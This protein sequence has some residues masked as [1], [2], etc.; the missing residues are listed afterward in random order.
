MFYNDI[1]KLSNQQFK[2]LTGVKREVFELMLESLNQSKAN[3]RK[4]PRRGTPPKL[5]NADKLLLMLMYYREYRTQ[6]HIGITYGISE[7]RVCEIIKETE[8]ILIQDSRF[9]LPGKKSLLKEEND[10]E[11]V[12]VDVT[13]SPVE[14]PKKNKS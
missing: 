10:F 11:V 6:F 9:H 3:S 1:K 2:R 5:S 13:E 8:E 14:R 4:H 7:S 12:L